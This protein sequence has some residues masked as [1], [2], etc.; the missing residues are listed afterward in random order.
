[1]TADEAI[2]FI[3]PAVAGR[4]GDWADLGAGT[5]TFTAALAAILGAPH[6]S[7]LLFRRYEAGIVPKMN[8]DP[9]C[10]AAAFDFC[11]TAP[12]N[13]ILFVDS[14]PGEFEPR[15]A[16][17]RGNAVVD[18]TTNQS[19][20]K[21]SQAVFP[22]MQKRRHFHVEVLGIPQLHFYNAPLTVTG[23]SRWARWPFSSHQHESTSEPLLIAD[24]SLDLRAVRG[25]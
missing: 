24:A 12:R 16:W 14:I 7:K 9:P 23:M 1:L 22:E 13:R 3:R 19:E 4:S 15:M 2:S 21:F 18:L 5:G 20:L 25:R 11:P 10:D 8:V 17:V 6:R